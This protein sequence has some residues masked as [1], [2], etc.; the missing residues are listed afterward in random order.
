MIFRLARGYISLLLALELLLLTAS[1]VL[2]VGVFFMGRTTAYDEYGLILFRAAVIVGIPTFAFVKDS[3]RWVNQIKSCPKWMWTGSLLLG[4]YSLLTVFF[5]QGPSFADRILT[6][7]G[8]PLGFEAISVCILYSVLSR[9]Y[10]ERAEVTRR[11]LH[12]VIIGC[13]VAAMFLAFRAGYLRRPA[14]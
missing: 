10:L 12:S 7:S 2:H 3:L 13:L 5:P 11:A 8:F 14:R 9:H 6:I 1:F 4:L